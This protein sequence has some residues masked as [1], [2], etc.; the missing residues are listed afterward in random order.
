MAIKK[1]EMRRSLR[2]AIYRAFQIVEPYSYI[3]DV[4]EFFRTNDQ[5]LFVYQMKTLVLGVIAEK[6]V[7]FIN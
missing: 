4:D 6:K 2:T 3:K 7:S 1:E 5:D